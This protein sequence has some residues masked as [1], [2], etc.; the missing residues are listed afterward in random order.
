MNKITSKFTPGP[1]TWGKE[2]TGHNGFPIHC[3]VDTNEVA[4]V[5]L[6][7][8]TTSCPRK[9]HYKLPENAESVANA[10]LIASAPELLEALKTLVYTY[11]ANINSSHEFIKCIT[12]NNIPEYWLRAKYLINKI[13]EGE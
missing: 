1:W 10:Q 2:P 6:N 5:Y 4:T 8:Y 13:E 7:L 12:P 11:I 9:E 3:G